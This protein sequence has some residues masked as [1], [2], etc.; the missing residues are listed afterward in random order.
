MHDC[1]GQKGVHEQTCG[2]R[3]AHTQKRGA[4]T[5]TLDDKPSE[6][7]ADCDTQC[8]HGLLQPQC[9]ATE[10]GHARGNICKHAALTRLGNATACPKP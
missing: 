5:I 7:R 9:A 10:R 4:R 2:S 3:S 6:G 8:I 1:L